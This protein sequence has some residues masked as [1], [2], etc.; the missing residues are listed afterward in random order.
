MKKEQWKKHKKIQSAYSMN[1]KWCTLIL[2]H[3]DPIQSQ[4]PDTEWQNY[5]QAIWIVNYV[6]QWIKKNKKGMLGAY[7]GVDGASFLTS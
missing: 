3:V 7:S 5:T 1:K 2:N 6:F 4:R